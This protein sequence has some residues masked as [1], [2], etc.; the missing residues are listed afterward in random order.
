[1]FSG[2]RTLTFLHLEEGEENT[3][4][5]FGRKRNEERRGSGDDAR[6]T[7][8]EW[9]GRLKQVKVYFY[10][11]YPSHLDLRHEFRPHP[12]DYAEEAKEDQMST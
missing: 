3:N 2:A 8:I 10:L 12:V 1:M 11:R 4:E 5:Y 7:I 6:E 9:G